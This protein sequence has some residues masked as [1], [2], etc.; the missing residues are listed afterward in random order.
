MPSAPSTAQDP[1]LAAPASVLRNPLAMLVLGIALL[2]AS[3]GAFGIA[4]SLSKPASGNGLATWFAAGSLAL[5]HAR[6]EQQAL[7]TSL[8]N[9]GNAELAK[10]TDEVSTLEKNLA[11]LTGQVAN[12]QKQLAS[13][14]E[15]MTSSESRQQALLAEKPRLEKI[16]KA[17][18]AALRKK[19]AADAAIKA[20]MGTTSMPFTAEDLK[21]WQTDWDRESKEALEKIREARNSLAGLRTKESQWIKGKGTFTPQQQKELQTGLRSLHAETTAKLKAARDTADAAYS[22]LSSLIATQR[23]QLEKAVLAPSP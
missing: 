18:D 22:K 19:E 1:F 5:V 21:A 8:L 10:L 9:S 6:L 16:M 15:Q 12:E 23:K 3:L 14:T 17:F 2:A 4:A 13:L 11:E 7:I 20:A